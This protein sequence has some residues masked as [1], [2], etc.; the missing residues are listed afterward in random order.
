MS[1]DTIIKINF[2]QGHIMQKVEVEFN[3][4]LN[5]KIC[6]ATACKTSEE[7]FNQF[8][9]THIANDYN[10]IANSFKQQKPGE[11]EN[12]TPFLETLKNI[13]HSVKN[14]ITYELVSQQDHLETVKVKCSFDYFENTIY[15]LEKTVE[16]ELFNK[17]IRQAYFMVKDIPR[18]VRM[19]YENQEKEIAHAVSVYQ[20][21]G[22][23]LNNAKSA[24]QI[25]G[26]LVQYEPF[27]D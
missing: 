20:L 6:E 1:C 2:K 22:D 13:Q 18:L 27:P 10:F 7:F 23:M 14:S 16:V 12:Y 24:V 9:V 21:V 15:S 26:K 11:E 19:H 8:V 3:V 5:K 25:N 4:V 17:N